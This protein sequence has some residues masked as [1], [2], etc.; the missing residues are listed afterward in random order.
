MKRAVQ[1]CTFSFS[2]FVG[3]NKSNMKSRFAIDLKARCVA[4][5][6]QAFKAHKGQLFELKSTCQMS[7]KQLLS[8]T[9][10]FVVY[11]AKSTPMCVQV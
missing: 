6:Y 3:K 8:A 10:V 11:T 2:M 1:N 4:E 7:S 5:L 9:K